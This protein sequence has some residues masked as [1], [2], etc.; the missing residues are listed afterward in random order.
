MPAEVRPNQ[1]R[2][3]QPTKIRQL[4]SN[5]FRKQSLPALRKQ[6]GESR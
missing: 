2:G 1:A 6:A 4:V 3:L 5:L